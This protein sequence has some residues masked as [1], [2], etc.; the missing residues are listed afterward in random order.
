MAPGA[1]WIAFG[2][3]PVVEL[4]LPAR[5][6]NPAESTLSAKA[7]QPFFD[8]LL[9]ICAPILYGLVVYYVWLLAAKEWTLGERLMSVGNV[10][11]VLG[12]CGINVAH[13]LGH[14]EGGLNRWMARILLL[15][16]LYNHFTIEHNYG[17]H[18]RVATPEDPATARRDEP[19]YGFFFRSI[20]GGYRHAWQIGARQL[21]DQG[22]SRWQHEMIWAHGLQLAWLA[23]ITAYAGWAALA[24]YLGA[25]IFGI[26]AL[27]A[28]NYVEHYGMV[29]KRL[30][31]GR[32]E[33]QTHRH[34]WNSNHE[35]G[36]IMLFELV[37]HADHHYQS[38][39]KYQT[40]RHLD[41]SPQLPFGYPMSIL[42]ALLP[43]V[44][45]RVM[46]PRLDALGEVQS[47][48]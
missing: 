29:R 48:S 2:I 42:L 32:Y 24:T 16:V 47:A 15:P 25:A 13:E 34:S 12:V 44:W 3:I 33:A 45:F 8:L 38:T 19:L 40:L 22:R 17:H 6:V 36:R 23:G 37:R 1:L 9:Y 28:V 30:P 41:E 14:R 26:L 35:L 31:S 46:N 20:V 11:V 39:R 18:L 4:F 5:A 43:G 10:G 21:A 27:E 7:Q